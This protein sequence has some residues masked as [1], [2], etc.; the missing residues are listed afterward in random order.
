MKSRQNLL[1]I[2][3]DSEDLSMPQFDIYTRAVIKIIN[4][5]C[6]GIIAINLTIA[7]IF[8]YYLHDSRV[9]LGG[10]IEIAML[11]GVVFLNVIRRP[12]CAN[13]LFLLTLNLATLYFGIILGPTLSIILMLFFLAGAAMFVFQTKAEIIASLIF[14]LLILSI[15]IIGYDYR[16]D[17]AL[18]RTIAQQNWLER[19]G[20][21]CVFTLVVAIFG[22]FAKIKN[23]MLDTKEK[24]IKGQDELIIHE[25]GLNSIRNHHLRSVAH[26]MNLVLN[27]TMPMAE[28]VLEKV[29]NQPEVKELVNYFFIA[30][31]NLQ[32]LGSNLLNADRL[33][34]GQIEPNYELC[35]LEEVI[36][37]MIKLNELYAQHEEKVLTFTGL[38]QNSPIP[39]IVADIS[40]T[41]MVINNLLQNAIR[42]GT[43]KTEIV[44]SLRANINSIL[45]SVKNSVKEKLS[46]TQI[47]ELFT[48]SH[49]RIE[50]TNSKRVGIG[51]SVSKK[52]IETMNGSLT[53]TCE[54]DLIAFHVL[55]P[56]SNI[57]KLGYKK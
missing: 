2:Q 37:E 33:E 20:I 51:L 10:S 27:M 31:S 26:E 48:D 56:K 53:V 5:F 8:S 22:V 15:L 39:P 52:C 1:S 13:I 49:S 7:P 41:K 54:E 30:H 43:K 34:R 17:V 36:T 6:L 23:G 46:S 42:Y 11:T 14:S 28:L 24:V 19:I 16:I 50:R 21:L 3:N 25:Q 38:V 29:Q 47:D 4:Y 44:V 45:I 35:E 55:L 12:K 18:S 57:S 40:M 9:L 32:R